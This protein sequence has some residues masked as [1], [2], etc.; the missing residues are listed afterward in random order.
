MQD[1]HINDFVR[2]AILAQNR[3][4]HQL[5]PFSLVN[6]RVILWAMDQGY[7]E[8]VF[9]LAMIGFFLIICVVAVYLFIRQ[10]QREHP[11]TSDKKQRNES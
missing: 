1:E 7:T 2:R 3:E 8:L 10:W 11:K 4:Q 9:V 6:S 5:L